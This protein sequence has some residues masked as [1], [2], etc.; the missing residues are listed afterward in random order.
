L[1]DLI[2]RRGLL[3]DGTGT[4]ARPADLAVSDGRV[5]EIGTIGGTAR[6]ELDAD[7]LVV[8]PG[9]IDLHTHYDPHVLW[10]P[11]VTPSSLHGVTTIVGGN[12]G[13]S[14]APIDLSAA[15]YLLPMLARVEGM[16]LESLEHAVQISWGSFG[17]W[18]GQLDGR[19]A[20]NVGFLAGHSTIRRLV[21]GDE[22]VGREATETEQATME[23]VL[24]DSLSQGALGFSSSLGAFHTD[25]HGTPVPSRWASKE[26]LLALC[27]SLRDHPGTTL[28]F[29]PP[30]GALFDDSVYDLMTSMSLAAQ[31]PLNWN[32]LRVSADDRTRRQAANR[33]AASQ[34]AA[35]AGA[36]V[37]ALFM[38]TPLRVWVNLAGGLLYEEIPGWFDVMTLPPA[39][40][41]RAFASVPVRA[42]LAESAAK[43][44]QWPWT[45]W[46]SLRVAQVRDP[47]LAHLVGHSIGDLAQA[48]GKEPFDQLLDIVIAD[49]GYPVFMTPVEGDDE[50]SWAQRA[51]SL[52]DPN[53]VIGGSDAGAHLDSLFDFACHTRFL[54]EMVRER[55]LLPLEEA[56]RLISDVPARFYGLRGR[57]RLV[58][59]ACADIVVFDPA[60][61]GPGTPEIRRDLPSQGKR[62]F[63]QP[64]G[65][66][67]VLVNG[68]EVASKGELTGS[69]PGAVLRS[70]RDTRTV[71]L[72]S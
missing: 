23:Q 58:P 26:E 7:G 14:V 48:N 55:G 20:L 68:T 49:D 54:S 10:D 24:H 59:G 30:G 46:P 69:L 50:D 5:V 28:E 53:I 60:A 71:Q 65:I 72:R 13:F 43:H 38:P 17:E 27:G 44:T 2:I 47:E 18:L 1:H 70:G 22:A 62:L 42:Q 63:S 32:L 19:V 37:V 15:D 6:R 45:A 52:R 35:T 36:R 34:H 57:G 4:P 25:H 61:I 67:A 11:Y 12:C 21:M 33:L 29:S 39:E 8:A 51:D 66:D 9:F 3:V 40:R 41:L 16:P 56:V 31:R 64:D